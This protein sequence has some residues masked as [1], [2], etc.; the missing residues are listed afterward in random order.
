MFDEFPKVMW[1]KSIRDDAGNGD[2]NVEKAI[3]ALHDLGANTIIVRLVDEGQ[4]GEFLTFL[5]QSTD[6]VMHIWVKLHPGCEDHCRPFGVT[7]K[8][9]GRTL[10]LSFINLP[11]A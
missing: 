9:V 8:R 6:S 5:D 2:I 10:R 4:Y 3:Q 7:M 1:F 11:S